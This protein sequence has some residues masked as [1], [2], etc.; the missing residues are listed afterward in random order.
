MQQPDFLIW[1][2]TGYNIKVYDP[3]RLVDVHADRGTERDIVD[4]FMVAVKP[5][6]VTASSPAYT[7]GMFVFSKAAHPRISSPCCFVIGGSDCH[8]PRILNLPVSPSVPNALLAEYLNKSKS[9]KINAYKAVVYFRVK[10]QQRISNLYDLLVEN[11]HI[12]EVHP[13]QDTPL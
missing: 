4:I 8:P 12:S 9:I 10:L 13:A 2:L 11:I 3:R 1:A 5:Y 6:L 7:P